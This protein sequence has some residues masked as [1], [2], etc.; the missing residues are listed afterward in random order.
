[1]NHLPHLVRAAAR[2]FLAVSL[3]L[4]LV[5]ASVRAADS[6]TLSGNVSNLATGNLLEGA[7]LEIPALNRS[8]LTDK[9]GRYVFSDLPPGAHEIV[10]TY[11]GL[12]PTRA[13]VNVTAGLPAMRNFDLTT[14][15]YKL[16]AFKVT[17][18][19]EGGAAAITAARNAENLKNVAATDSF[20][21]LPNMNAGEVAIRLPGI[22]GELD[23]GGNLSGFTVRGM[24][25][26]L[27]TVRGFDASTLPCTVAGEILDFDARKYEV[28]AIA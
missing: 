10:V 19:R 20:G 5:V 3:P 26:G 12:D 15:I 7:R 27:N 18:E 1:M 4:A 13:N 9:T 14:G 21:N 22:Y 28:R 25:S 17:G 24:T 8:A 6:A 16:D 2:L 23:A 11:T